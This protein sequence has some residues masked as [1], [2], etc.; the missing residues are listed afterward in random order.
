[1]KRMLAEMATEEAGGL[2]A[3]F[4]SSKLK[5]LNETG[6]EK[7]IPPVQNNSFMQCLYLPAGLRVARAGTA[8]D[9]AGPPPSAGRLEA[10]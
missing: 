9:P 4:S 1:M 6:S 7:Q 3:Q 8:R 2:R 5:M 10:P